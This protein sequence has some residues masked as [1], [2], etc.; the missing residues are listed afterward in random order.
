MAFFDDDRLP[1]EVTD[2]ES[3]SIGEDQEMFEHFRLTADKGQTPVRIDKYMSSHL[4]DTS[5]HRIQ[6]AIKEGYVLLN[7][8]TAKANMIVRPG[9]LIRFVMPYRRRGMEIL[10]QDIPLDVVYEDD[11]LL[12]VNK[13]A[14]MVVHPGHGHFEGTLINAL[15][16]HLGLSQGPDAEDERMGILVHRIDKDTSGLLVVAKTDEAQMNLAKQFFVHS[17][18]R[19][20]IAVVWG[21]IKENEGTI[22]G[23]IGRDPN[24][25]LRYKVYEDSDKGKHAV[26]HYKVLERF[27]YVTVVE[28]RLETGRTH[29]I[30]VH[31]SHIGHPLFNDAR[32]GG[33]EIRK[34]T[35]YA[36]YK[37]FIS[38][39]FEICPRQALHARTLGFVH[40]VTGKF[41]RFDSELPDDMK[42]LIE[43]WRKYSE[44]MEIE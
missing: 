23:N 39:C 30:R 8:K 3:D 28:C 5:R 12:I 29:Q 7:G 32:Y 20:Y 10:P 13:P 37:Q 22:D 33:A 2:P 42:T 4:E 40:P 18:E 24:D 43:K 38:N 11:S 14:G 25:R 36:K 15:A 19:C 31:F 16:Y 34:G 35:I 41:M 27:G 1:E 21:N 26:T 17:I 6:I 9:D 44:N